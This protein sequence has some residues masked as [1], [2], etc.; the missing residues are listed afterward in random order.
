MNSQHEKTNSK[1]GLL[2]KISFKR[3]FQSFLMYKNKS[4]SK[5]YVSYSKIKLLV[6]ESFA[7]VNYLYNTKTKILKKYYNFLINVTFL[8][9]SYSLTNMGRWKNLMS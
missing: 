5:I 4:E 1:D 7:Y 2:K 9:E 6:L 3:S 8:Y